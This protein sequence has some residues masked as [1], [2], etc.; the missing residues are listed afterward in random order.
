MS[1]SDRLL[2]ERLIAAGLLVPHD[3]IKKQVRA[4]V[5]QDFAGQRS[6]AFEIFMGS[7]R[8]WKAMT[9]HR[10]DPVVRLVFAR[11]CASKKAQALKA[12]VAK[13]IKRGR[14]P[15]RRRDVNADWRGAA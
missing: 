1:Y 10:T 15:V 14:Y 2:R 5:E 6:A 7:E 9:D 13:A 8:G 12:A 3:Q 11:L 4:V